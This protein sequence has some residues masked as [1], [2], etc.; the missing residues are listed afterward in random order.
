MELL[1]ERTE[2][3]NKVKFSK[4]LKKW[5]ISTVAILVVVVAVL[6][7]AWIDGRNSGMEKSAGQISELELTIEQLKQKIQDLIDN[8]IIVNPV[9]PEINLDKIRSEI[10]DIAE[11]ATTEY[12]FTNAAEFSESKKLVNWDIPFTEKSFMLKWDGMIKAGVSLENIGIQVVGEE[13]KIIVTLP[14]SQI[15]TYEVDYDSVEVLDEHDGLFNPV[16]VTDKNKFDIQTEAEM[17]ERAI[18]NGILEKA[19]KNAEIILSGL[20]ISDPAISSYY[21]VEFVT[22]SE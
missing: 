20:L 3:K 11:L 21:T 18:E 5:L 16:T 17:L 15:L 2:G 6:L 7:T 1:D 14:K 13:K 8:P 9:A 10:R 22:A 19:Q 12:F 4:K